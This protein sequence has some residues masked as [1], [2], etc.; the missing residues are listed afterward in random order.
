MGVAIV[1]ETHSTTTDNEAGIA[2][3]WLPGELSAAGRRQARE[4]GQRRRADH[5]SAVFVS[6]LRRAVQ[7]AQLAFAGSGIPIH[8]DARLRECDYGALNGMPVTRLAAERARRI[9]QPFPGGQSYRQVVAQMRGFLRD[10]AA[11]WAGG[12]VVVI[13]HSANK[14]ALDCL[15]NG[16]ALEDLVDAPFGWQPGWSYI[17]PAGWT[18]EAG[19]P[20]SPSPPQLR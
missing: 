10:L 14:W 12:R 8:Q 7:T 5:I 3:G 4:L 2:T 11:G 15:L 9:D 16:H 18:G 1:Y 20:G 17:L 13:A 19:A 6:D